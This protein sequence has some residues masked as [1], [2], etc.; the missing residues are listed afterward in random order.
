MFDGKYVATAMSASS[1]INWFFNFVVSMVFPYLNEYLGPY[2]FVP[3]ASVLLFGFI[4]TAIWLPETQG[5]TPEELQ[6]RLIKKNE[7]VVYHNMSFVG[8]MVGDDGQ[9]GT[10][11][12]EWRMAM[13]QVRKEEED[14]MNVG[15]FNYGFKPIDDKVEKGSPPAPVAGGFM[16]CAYY[17]VS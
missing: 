5:T 15:T 2:S 12:D 9:Q 11:G 4:F 17:L 1:Q 14:A 3:F 10:L 13:D 7:S 16:A 6:A 8:D